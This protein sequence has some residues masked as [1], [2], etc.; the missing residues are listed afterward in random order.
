[1]KIISKSVKWTDYVID[2]TYLPN[3]QLFYFP[4]IT[5]GNHKYMLSK[6]S[7]KYGAK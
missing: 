2:M 1:M 7:S 4:N 5:H 3:Y 6:N